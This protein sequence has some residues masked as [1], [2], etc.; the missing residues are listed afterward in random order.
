V[1]SWPLSIAR[2][3][4]RLRYANPRDLPS[5]PSLGLGRDG[6]AANKAASL[7]WAN[8]R[9]P[10]QPTDSATASAAAALAR[11]SR[12]PTTKA[13]VRGTPSFKRVQPAVGP[14]GETARQWGA[15]AAGQAFK[16]HPPQQSSQ[17]DA[18]AARGMTATALDRQRSLRA[19]RLA[20]A[21]AGIGARRMSGSSPRPFEPSYPDKANAA[22]NAL[23]AAS[24]AHKPLVRL[25]A[26]QSGAVPYTTMDRRM[27]TSHPPVK[28]EVDEKR[29]ADVIHASALAMA[30]RMYTQQL[31]VINAAKHASHDPNARRPATADDEPQPAQHINLQEA[32]Y[33]LAQERLAKLH[34]EHQQNRDFY[35]YYGTPGA[36]QNRFAVRAKLRRRASSDGAVVEDRRRSQQI[37]HQMSVFS[38]RLSQVDEQ[39]RR[40]DREAVLAAA[41]RNVQAQL[42]EMDKRVYAAT[43]KP[44]PTLLDKWELKAH[45]TAQAR[46]EAR[47]DSNLGKIDVGGGLYLD[48]KTVDE[49]AAKRVQPIIDDIHE[50]ADKERERRA[51]AKM[52]EETRQ[53][54]VER[55]RAR[56]REIQEI[57]ETIKSTYPITATKPGPML[58]THRG[59]EGKGQASQ[60]RTRTRREGTK[61]R[62]KD[63]QGPIQATA[64][65]GEGEEDGESRHGISH[66]PHRRGYPSSAGDSRTARRQRPHRPALPSPIQA[67]DQAKD[68]R[69]IRPA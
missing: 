28:P 13:G 1:S 11:E 68:A 15:S 32:A 16:A 23:S 20:D 46:S 5:F 18:A 47:K 22:A 55:E 67:T 17:V 4:G 64:E 7:G 39:K 58:T 10:A 27:F 29:R 3:D 14:I 66:C 24:L 57:H 53:R 30:R 45:T 19:A 6:A 9:A 25:P 62:R 50:E 60:R 2:L 63:R 61:T 8:Q 52:E 12:A 49:I 31:R 37:R 38:T 26:D 51:A 40:R 56:D 65:G 21:G 54:E 36:P 59:T 41:Q 34:E 42:K 33:K 35:E 48:R 44:T 69:R 43:G